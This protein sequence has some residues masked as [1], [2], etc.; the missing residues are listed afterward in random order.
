MHKI[1]NITHEI[2]SLFKNIS[3]IPNLTLQN[4]IFN[5]TFSDVSF[6]N[7]G[8]DGSIYKAKHIIDDKW[9]AIKKIPFFINK[10]NPT[11][12]VAKNILNKL[13]EVRCMSALDH[14]NIIKYYTSWIEPDTIEQNIVIDDTNY[15][16]IC[17]YVQM[18]LMQLSLREFLQDIDFSIRK[19]NIQI[20][21]NGI[22]NGVEYL[23]EKDIIHRDLKPEN[24]LL[25][26]EDNNIIDI[27]IADFSLVIEKQINLNNSEDNVGTPVYTPPEQYNSR[28]GNKYDIYSLGIIIYEIFQEFRTFMET[29]ENIKKLQIGNY[30]KTLNKLLIKMI[31]TDYNKRPDMHYI[32]NNLK[33]ENLF[34]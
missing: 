7:S 18:E 17:L 19:K 31:N 32:K 10:E 8:S 25:N 15:Y 1:S 33:I 6:I 3:Q 24:V 34:I 30:P 13:K 5:N 21:V 12:I 14:I 27:K 26:L 9:Y 4:N 22:L 2:N 28:I 11:E 23:H 29:Y 16:S 20:L